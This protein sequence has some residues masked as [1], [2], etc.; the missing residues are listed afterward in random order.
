M[1]KVSGWLN[2]LRSE[3]KHECILDADPALVEPIKEY[4]KVLV[5]MEKGIVQARDRGTDE[6][7]IFESVN[8]FDNKSMQTAKG[9]L[10][11]ALTKLASKI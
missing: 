2:S 3:V 8:S 11:K 4:I 1:P 9:K 5:G 7:G 10:K 6:K